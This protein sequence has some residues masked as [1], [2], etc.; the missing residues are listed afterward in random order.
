MQQKA[1]VGFVGT[2]ETVN[3]LISE[4]SK[5][6]VAKEYKTRHDWVGKGIH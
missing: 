1:S 4:D 3:N 2:D 5:G 6:I